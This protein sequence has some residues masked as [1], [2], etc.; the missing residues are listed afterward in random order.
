MP[1]FFHQD[2]TFETPLSCVI[3]FLPGNWWRGRTSVCWVSLCLLKS[4]Y[5]IEIHVKKEDFEKISL[6][7]TFL[8]KA[9]PQRSHENG[10]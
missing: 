3:P 9:R 2:Q 4:T 8:W 5:K 10:L 7:L 1:R 6:V